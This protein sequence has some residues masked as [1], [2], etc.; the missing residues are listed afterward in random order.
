MSKI[1]PLEKDVNLDKRYINET[2]VITEDALASVISGGG[3][4]GG[5]Q[6]IESTVDWWSIPVA[7]TS[8]LTKQECCEL[9]GISEPDLDSIF[10]S[11]RIVSLKE[12]YEGS[13][14]IH[15]MISRFDG[16]LVGLGVSI[17]WMYAFTDN[18][19]LSEIHSI[20]L[21]K[22]QSAYIAFGL[23]E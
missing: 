5:A 8:E 16:S 20:A 2:D 4:G 7:G 18:N 22:T 9:T 11:D 6:I 1:L 10:S 23:M 13:S 17:M 14:T 12:V 3:S 21:M 15:P 19:V